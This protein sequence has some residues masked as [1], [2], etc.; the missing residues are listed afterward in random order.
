MTAIH[1]TAYPRLKPN[2]STDELEK[3]FKPTYDEIFLMEDSTKSSLSDVY[4]LEGVRKVH[5]CGSLITDLSKKLPPS[6]REYPFL[7]LLI[8]LDSVKMQKI[9]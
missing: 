4:K 7:C 6:Y 9:M 2:P 8:R 1:E 5:A 3:N